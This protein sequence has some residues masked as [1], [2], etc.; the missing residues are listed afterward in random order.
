MVKLQVIEFET[1]R[2]VTRIR[3]RLFF[4]LF[5]CVCVFFYITSISRFFE[6]IDLLIIGI[7]TPKHSE[8]LCILHI[9]LLVRG[10]DTYQNTKK[11]DSGF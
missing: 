8:M 3:R 10:L 5:V 1:Y 2:D 6:N 7:L 9:L 11:E 4:C